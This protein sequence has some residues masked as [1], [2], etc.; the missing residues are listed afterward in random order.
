MHRT[1]DAN[2][3]PKTYRRLQVRAAVGGRRRPS[4]VGDRPERRGR[5]PAPMFDSS[6]EDRSDHRKGGDVHTRASTTCSQTPNS[7]YFPAA[8]GWR[9]LAP[10][11]LG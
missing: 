1:T 3:Y 9:G 10:R 7:A 4:H 2:S 8:N 6:S 11:D 5:M